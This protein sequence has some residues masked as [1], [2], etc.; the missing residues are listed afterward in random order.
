MVRYPFLNHTMLRMEYCICILLSYQSELL[1]IHLSSHPLHQAP[2][3]VQVQT[4]RYEVSIYDL[5]L[6]E[7]INKVWVAKVR[8]RTHTCDVRSH[9]CVQNPIWKVCGMCVRAARFWACDVRSHFC[10]L[11]GTILCQKM[12]L[13]VLKTVLKYIFLF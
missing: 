6:S 1:W 13:F 12:K 7:S 5:R 8:A 9:V 2:K 11:F 3:I 4:E 10:T